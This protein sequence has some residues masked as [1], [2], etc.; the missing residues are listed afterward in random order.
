MWN[1]IRLW[2]FMRR[3]K[4]RP[5]VVQDV[6]KTW[7]IVRIQA[8]HLPGDEPTMKTIRI[9]IDFDPAM[10][11]HAMDCC[12]KDEAAA[13]IAGRIYSCLSILGG[14]R[15]DQSRGKVT[16]WPTGYL[17]CERVD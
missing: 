12:D 13:Y 2:K 11:D 5:E 1:P 6:A 4:E 15:R 16:M 7:G 3:R 8:A 17:S 9:W 10:I 14:Y